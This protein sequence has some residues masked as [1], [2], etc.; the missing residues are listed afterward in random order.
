MA[1]SFRTNADGDEYQAVGLDTSIAGER[2]TGSATASW[3]LAV[4]HGNVTRLNIG[5]T[6]TLVTAAPCVVLTL[7]GNDGNT[8]YSAL[9]DANATGGGS[10]PQYLLNVGD[11]VNPQAIFG[12]FENGLTVQGEDALHDV[13]VVWWPL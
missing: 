13:T 12:R 10:T 1:G 3:L 4:P 9:R 7:T 5:T 8:G 6:E 2:Q 11:G